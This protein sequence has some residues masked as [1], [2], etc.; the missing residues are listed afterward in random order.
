M[1][2]IMIPAIMVD[3]RGAAGTC[4]RGGAAYYH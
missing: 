3:T 4:R 2:I 1:S